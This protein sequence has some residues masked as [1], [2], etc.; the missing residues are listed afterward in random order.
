[1][2]TDHPALAYLRNAHQRAEAL[3]KATTAVPAAGEWVAVRDKH[4]DRDKPLALVQGLDPD[5]AALDGEEW[6]DAEDYAYGL[7]VIAYSA[8]WQDEAEANLRFIAANNPASV[9]RRIEADR[10]ILTEHQV[11]E[12]RY[13]RRCAQWLD[14]PIGQQREA[15]DA[16]DYPCQTVRLLAAGWGWIAVRRESAV[17]AI[18]DDELSALLILAE[19]DDDA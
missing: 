2:T 16:V 8:D 13:C 10:A 14:I 18:P 11:D 17:I 15:D 9:L 5:R 6:L 19:V 12:G 7:P 3:A 4:D 1:V